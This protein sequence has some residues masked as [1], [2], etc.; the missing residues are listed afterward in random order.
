MSLLSDILSWFW[1]NQYLLFLK[2]NAACLGEKQ[3]ILNLVFGMTQPRLKPMI[4]HTWD[5]YANHY[6]TDA[7]KYGSSDCV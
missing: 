4:Y 3:L 5:E 6:I 7:V 1:D 2:I